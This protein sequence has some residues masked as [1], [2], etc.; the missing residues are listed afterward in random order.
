[1]VGLLAI[2]PVLAN[3]DNWEELIVNEKGSLYFSPDS[4]AKDSL[5]RTTFWIKFNQE[6]PTKGTYPSQKMLVIVDCETRTTGKSALKSYNKNGELIENISINP[7]IAPMNSP[8]PD[9]FDM[10]VMK[11]ICD[12][13]DI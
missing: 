3:A 9:G 6:K 11:S 7:L 10:I 4:F 12:S 8:D 13:E 2:V 5:G 1:M